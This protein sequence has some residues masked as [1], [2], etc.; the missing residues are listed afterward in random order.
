M[1]R[2]DTTSL[3]DEQSAASG[4]SSEALLQLG[5]M[6]ATGR[7]VE[8]DYVMAHKWLNIAAARGNAIARSYRTELSRDMSRQE[9]ARAQRLAR[10]W[11]AKH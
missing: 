4:Q 3:V 2:R 8:M 9:I 7:D 11:M 5:L 6:Y 1:A 10:T